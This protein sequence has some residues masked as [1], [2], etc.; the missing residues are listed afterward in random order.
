MQK[1]FAVLTLAALAASTAPAAAAAPSF[2]DLTNHWAQAQVEAAAAAGYAAGYPD[3]TFRPDDAI[4]RAEFF[5]L[6]TAAMGQPLGP[7]LT[8]GFQIEDHWAFHQG[9]IQGAVRAGLLMPT[10]YGESFGPD[11]QITRREI[12]M[13]AIRALGL[14]PVSYDTEV[15]LDAADA[16]TYPTWLQQWA[17][18]A[19][20]KGLIT[21]YPDGSLQL[22]APATRAEALTI[23]QRL[24]PGVTAE[25]APAEAPP[26][27]AIRYR[28]EGEPT[29]QVADPT[30]LPYVISDGTN[31]YPLPESARNVS[32]LPSPGSACW[33]AYTQDGAD[34]SES[35]DVILRLQGGEVTQVFREPSA[36]ELRLLLTLDQ[37]GQVW[38]SD[39]PIL[40]VADAQGQVK[41]MADLKEPLF[42]GTMDAQGSFWG[43]GAS[44]KLWCVDGAGRAEAMD[45]DL[46]PTDVVVAVVPADQDAIWLLV[47]R[48]NGELESWLA[49]RG[50]LQQTLLLSAHATQP[51]AAPPVVMGLTGDDLWLARMTQTSSVESEQTGYLAFDLSDGTFRTLVLPE[52]VST[53]IRMRTSPEGTPLVED[54]AGSFWQILPHK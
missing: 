47:Y 25:V 3:G 53:P 29:W 37:Q 17:T 20:Q 42:L 10:D 2:S 38:F 54:A 14:E 36:G 43:I 39:G 18:L 28:A 19:L 44:G 21:G 50:L 35:V 34:S 15:Q 6:L 1:G 41:R 51:D 26:A 32:L 52:E 48:G 9:Y 11:T 31:G 45:T 30:T 12:L 16:E 33:V 27:A 5:K 22:D 23:I 8:V 13:A 49:A 4:T 40:K 24:L 7:G 46:Q